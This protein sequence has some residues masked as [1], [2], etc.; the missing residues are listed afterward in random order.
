M[1]VYTSLQT[2]VFTT[3]RVTGGEARVGECDASSVGLCRMELMA[4]ITPATSSLL[5]VMSH[6]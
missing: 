5:M 4:T 1:Y 2:C 6:L 3:E